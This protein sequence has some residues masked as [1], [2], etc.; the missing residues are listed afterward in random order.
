MLPPCANYFPHC[1]AQALRAVAAANAIARL[2]SKVFKTRPRAKEG[3][4]ARYTRSR[5]CQR[6]SRK[7]SAHAVA[8]CLPCAHHASQCT[9]EALRAEAAAYAT[10][11]RSSTHITYAKRACSCL[12]L[13]LCASCPPLYCPGAAGGGRGVRYARTIVNS[14]HVKLSVY[15]AALCLPCAH[16]APHYTTQA[17][18]A[19]AFVF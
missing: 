16:H 18:R 4:G 6:A 13:A 5:D 1:T 7:P 19:S 17:L 15:T 14:H 3:R 2:S 8:L 11:E 12:V 9:A 10:L